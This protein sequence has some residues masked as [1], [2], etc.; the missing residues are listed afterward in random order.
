VLVV[1]DHDVVQWGLRLVLSR[2]P[3]VGR[4]VAASNGAAAMELAQR[5]SPDVA[6][7]DLF[8]GSESGAELAR[9]IRE[10]SPRTRILLMSGVGSISRKA[11]QAAGAAGFVPKD[12]P[13]DKL[14][15]AVEQVAA[16][17]DVFPAREDAPGGRLTPREQEILTLMARGSTNRE[18][19]SALH[20]SPHT[21][22]EHTVSLY[23]ALEVRNRT[24]AVARAE[25]L[26]LVS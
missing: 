26:G 7:V 23:R 5:Y 17:R 10:V 16:G 21:V 22:K 19:A 1:D 11:A 2:H 3:R 13:A 8:L 20:L 4:C 14:V 6:M 9:R 15:L 18:I 24:E 25:R 12:W